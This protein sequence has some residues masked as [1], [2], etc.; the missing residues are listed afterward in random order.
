MPASQVGLMR[1]LQ[2]ILQAMLAQKDKIKN[3]QELLLDMAE[4]VVKAVSAEFGCKQD[5]VG[6]LLLSH[7]GRHLR[8][9]E[10]ALTGGAHSS[11]EHDLDGH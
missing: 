5:E 3:R 8:F 4:R 7:D 1:E 11:A 2:E 10:E 6:I 9:G